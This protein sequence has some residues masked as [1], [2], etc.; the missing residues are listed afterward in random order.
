MNPVGVQLAM[1]IRPPGRVDPQQLG[2]RPVGARREH[3]AEHRDHRREL[4][5]AIA[6]PTR[7]RPTSKAMG[8]PSPAAR[9]CA[10]VDQVRRDVDPGDQRPA[11]RRREREVAGAARDV[12]HVLAGFE[13]KS[14]DE[15]PAPS[16]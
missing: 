12:E 13:P 15:L 8:K 5:V 11:A 2:G 4:A 6:Q 1:A 3:R 16:A 10:W 9:A 7:R 14:R